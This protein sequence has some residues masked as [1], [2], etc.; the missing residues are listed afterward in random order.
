MKANRWKYS[1][2]VQI[3]VDYHKERWFTCA[4][5]DYWGEKTN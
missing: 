3:T 2:H 5:D 4:Y 1:R